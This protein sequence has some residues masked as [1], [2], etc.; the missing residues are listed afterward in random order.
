PDGTV[1]GNNNHFWNATDGCCDFGKTG[2]DDSSYLAGLIDEIASKYKVDPKRVYFMGHSN[3]GFMSYRMACDHADRVAAIVSLAGATFA[4][5]S[6]CK[7]T[8]PVAVVEVH[9]NADPTVPY[10]GQGVVPSAP[11]SS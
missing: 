11:T 3:G 6:K 2:V 10:D 9:G 5:D 1:D 8:A 7:P 4:D